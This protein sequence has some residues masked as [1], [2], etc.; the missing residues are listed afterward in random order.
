MYKSTVSFVQKR[1]ATL[2]GTGIA[3]SLAL[4]M[5]LTSPWAQGVPNTPPITPPITPP[6]SPTPTPTPTPE[7]EDSEIKITTNRLGTAHEGRFYFKRVKAMDSMANSGLM[8]ETS[9]LPDGLELDH[10]FTIPGFWKT[11]S[12]CYIKGVPQESGEFDVT[13]MAS[14]DYGEFEIKELE[15]KIKEGRRLFS[16]WR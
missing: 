10:C 6:S 7:P 8:I 15:L 11:S 13:I 1:L 9:E 12:F 2:L 16:W 5:T 3:L 14:N 4:G